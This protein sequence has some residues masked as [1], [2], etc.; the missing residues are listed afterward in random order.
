[1]DTMES[2]TPKKPPRRRWRFWIVAALSTSRL[3]FN[4]KWSV[5]G[6][7]LKKQTI[8]GEPKAQIKMILNEII[9]LGGNIRVY[10]HHSSHPKTVVDLHDTDFT[11]AGLARLKLLSR[12]D[13]LDLCGTKITDTGLENL[14][15]LPSIRSL[16]LE[17]TQVS[18]AGLQHTSALAQLQEL[19]LC[20]T[21][22]TGEGLK[23]L[24]GLGQLEELFICGSKLN[25]KSLEHLR[26][27]SHL[28]KLH[29]C[30]TEVADAGV[31]KLEKALPN[32]RIER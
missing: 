11:D 7:H 2:T 31:A 16:N 23:H 29:I 1:M 8:S 24:D 13:V 18:D 32:V 10:E 9:E 5:K 19:N 30:E 27:F 20:D 6:G 14:K 4:M 22:V 17:K 12:V 25:N 21:H 3:K 26:A 28:R 15:A